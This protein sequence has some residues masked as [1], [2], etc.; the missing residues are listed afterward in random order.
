MFTMPVA[1]CCVVEVNDLAAKCQARWRIH[2]R[3]RGLSP[4]ENK[5]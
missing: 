4:G 2:A 5:E 1:L 3:A